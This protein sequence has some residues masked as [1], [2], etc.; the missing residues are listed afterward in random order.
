MIQLFLHSTSN[1]DITLFLNRH[2]RNRHNVLYCMTVNVSLC[3]FY[4][5]GPIDLNIQALEQFVT[6]FYESLPVHYRM[7]HKFDLTLS[8]LHKFVDEHF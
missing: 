2:T 7:S 3:S 8:A 1:L 4:F 6:Q 5:H